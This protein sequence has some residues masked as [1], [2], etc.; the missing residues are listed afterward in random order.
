MSKQRV[1]FDANHGDVDVRGAHR[2][3]SQAEIWHDENLERRLLALKLG[4]P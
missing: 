2:N 3:A 1:I 4:A